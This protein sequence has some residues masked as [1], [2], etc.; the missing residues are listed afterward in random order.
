MN[1]AMPREAVAV[2]N[3]EEISKVTEKADNER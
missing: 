1:P 3:G 2:P